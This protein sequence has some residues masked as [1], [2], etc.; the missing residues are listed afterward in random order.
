MR[1]THRL[2]LLTAIVQI[3]R[4]YTQDTCSWNLLSSIP[5]QNMCSVENMI[6]HMGDAQD[7]ETFRQRNGSGDRKHNV[8]STSPD[9]FRGYCAYT[10]NDFFG[11][12]I[13]AVTTAPNHNRIKQI[14]APE[15]RSE[16]DNG[17]F[18]VVGIPGKGRGLAATRAIRRGER[19][20]AAK[21]ALLVHRD[22]FGE[23]PLQDVYSLMD[24]AV[25]SLSSLRKA[26]Y[27]AQAGTMGGHK[28]TDILFT[29][30]FQIALEENDGFHYGNFPEVSLLN[31]DC[32]PNLAFFI[33]QN[34]TH[35]THAVR[36]IKPGEE[37]TI[38]Y[39][40]PLEARSVRQER[41]RNSFG[42]SCG[43]SHCSLLKNESDASD[44]RLLIIS[45]IANELSD[46]SSKTSSPAMI[47]EYVSL[48]RKERLEYKIAE[49]YTLAALNYN[50][51]GKAEMAKKYALLAVDAGL[52]ES[53]SD[54]VGVQQMKMIAD[55]PKVHW[56]WNMKPYQ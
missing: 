38:S 1:A 50:L 17:I 46:F 10:N 33:D 34:L 53:D 4:A 48:Y 37:L 36:D 22:V 21:P 45:R 30:S 13:S 18:K 5:E 3:G 43:C 24:M 29:N 14:Q 23:L 40:D 11:E 16:S 25:N 54:A 9:C 32:R 6:D 42:F 39:V 15:I 41:T 52:L 31:H 20:M 27:L 12:G 49:A 2:T 26:S 56:S 7:G 47:E 8:W 28:I 44:S 19:I 51:F 55:D 35:Y